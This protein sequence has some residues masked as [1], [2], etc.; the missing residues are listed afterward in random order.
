LAPH[1]FADRPVSGPLPEVVRP[2]MSVF[3]KS[4]FASSSEGADAAVSSPLVPPK[5]DGRDNFLASG[6]VTRGATGSRSTPG[7]TDCASFSELPVGGRPG[8]VV[9]FFDISGSA[10]AAFLEVMNATTLRVAASNPINL[11]S[12]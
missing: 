9:A 6:L 3:G 8:A 10:T 2:M 12:A 5:R 4:P 11:S 7:E 1:F